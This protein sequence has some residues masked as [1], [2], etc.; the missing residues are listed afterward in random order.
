MALLEEYADVLEK[1]SIDEAYIDCTNKIL[2]Q[3]SMLQDSQSSQDD[4]K[5]K[6]E[7]SI[8]SEKTPMPSAFEEYALK[9]KNS[10]KEQ[11][12]GLLCSIG[13]AP[14]KSA[15]KIASDFE[16]P[17]GLTVVY[18]DD[19]LQFLEPL[20]VSSIAGI[21]IKTNQVLKEMGINTIGQLAK[22]DVQ[23]L[24][25]RFGKK[26]GLW[27]WHV[28]N[29]KDHE[30]ALPR[31]DNLSPSAEE[32]LQKPTKD[33]KVILEYLLNELVDDIYERTQRRGYEFKTVGIKL[34]R[35]DFCSRDKRNNVF[36][37]S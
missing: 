27:M 12:D 3:Q 11:C 31:E 32:T 35:S 26:N 6:K 36:C 20:D 28:A 1:A 9:F 14:T 33:K 18:S 15:A 19:L 10:I 23:N 25:D 16:K 30:P 7:E 21:G 37:L 24:I 5:E 13:L 29:G 22:R 8:E 34:M 17:D 4:E 2:Q